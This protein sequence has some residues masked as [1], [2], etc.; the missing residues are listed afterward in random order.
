MPGYIHMSKMIPEDVEI[1][2]IA[3]LKT[4][5]AGSTQVYG[6]LLAVGL[7]ALFQKIG[8]TYKHSVRIVLILAFVSALL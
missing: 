5:Q 2:I 4:M 7:V 1:T 6:R 8:Y 3:L